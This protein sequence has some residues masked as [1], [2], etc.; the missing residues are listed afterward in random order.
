MENKEPAP[1]VSCLSPCQNSSSLL[2]QKYT[3]SLR[4]GLGE[5]HMF[6]CCAEQE[7]ERDSNCLLE[8]Q[9][10]LLL[11]ALFTFTSRS[12]WHRPSRFSEA[13]SGCLLSLP[14]AGL[15]FSFLGSAKSVVIHPSVFQRAKLGFCCLLFVEGL[16]LF[17]F[18]F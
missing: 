4:P 14:A 8:L 1:A 9:T 5:G 7:R 13:Q 17:F 6:E 2:L 15:G 11:S 3:L 16:Y 18:S 10:T 12:T